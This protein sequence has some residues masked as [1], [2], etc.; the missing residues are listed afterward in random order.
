MQKN[1]V[2]DKNMVVWSL[3]KL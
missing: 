2:F 3:W 1:R